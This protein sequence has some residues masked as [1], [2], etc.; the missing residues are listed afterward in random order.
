MPRVRVLPF[1]PASSAGV[2][3]VTPVRGPPT[4]A[5]S[6]TGGA[7]APQGSYAPEASA[8]RLA[9]RVRANQSRLPEALPKSTDS[10]SPE[11]PLV[12]TRIQRRGRQCRRFETTTKAAHFAR[13]TLAVATDW[14][15]TKM[16]K[17]L[18]TLA[19]EA[20]A[21]VAARLAGALAVQRAGFQRGLGECRDV[22]AGEHGLR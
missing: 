6:P 8:P 12:V 10:Q 14:R 1:A 17:D 2:S 4:P 13:Q 18:P 7:S 22:C 21:A 19:P 11:E 15:T 9:D 16:S 5:G 3:P 20:P